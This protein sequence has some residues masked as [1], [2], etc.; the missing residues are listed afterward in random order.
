M[1]NQK[2]TPTEAKTSFS[3]KISGLYNRKFMF[4]GQKYHLGETCAA[5]TLLLPTII[6]LIIL[7]VLP[8]IV[9]LVLSVNDF[10]VN[11]GYFFR[12]RTP[13]K[14]ENSR[15]GFYRTGSTGTDPNYAPLPAEE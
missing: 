7:F 2:T 4:R 8:L 14:R 9:L 10:R 13:Q 1:P 12:Y 5:Y 3:D 6:S 15:P 11:K